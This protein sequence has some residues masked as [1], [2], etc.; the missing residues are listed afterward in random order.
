MPVCEKTLK[1]NTPVNIASHTKK[2][3]KDGVYRN[4]PSLEINKK[5]NG[6]L[7]RRRK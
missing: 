7:Y 4:A 6:N 2:I 1:K 5:H 3:L